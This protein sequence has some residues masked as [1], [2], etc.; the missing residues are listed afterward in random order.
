M[1]GRIAS[2]AKGSGAKSKGLRAPSGREL[3]RAQTRLAA[4][5]GR[6]MAK[7]V[8]VDALLGGT[9]VRSPSSPWFGS[10]VRHV[11]RVL[12]LFEQ[13]HLRTLSVA[14]LEGGP[15]AN[16]RGMVFTFDRF[17][18]VARIQ[19]IGALG[20][21]RLLEQ[22]LIDAAKALAEASPR[23]A[24]PEGAVFP[25][26]YWEREPHSVP[27]DGRFHVRDGIRGSVALRDLFEHPLDYSLD[28][29]M[30]V[31]VVY[32]KALLSLLGDGAFDSHFAPL[33]L[34][35]RIG[36]GPPHSEAALAEWS[37]SNLAPRV[38]LSPDA[39]P[40]STLIYLGKSPRGKRLFYGHPF[41]ITTDASMNR[42]LQAALPP[43][44]P[45]PATVV[46]PTELPAVKPPED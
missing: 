32:F 21:R 16:N 3:T 45:P 33:T 29:R 2:S 10:M 41:G 24:F 34:S 19:P 28:A 11:E 36:M 13:R 7:V 17:N 18:R 25:S 1:R 31:Q 35:S 4:D 8:L 14:G 20:N 38:A 9:P 5:L 46:T 40:G 15:E 39:W 23:F 37:A 44:T 43:N 26:M 6:A 22:S 42:Y 27:A 12:H 30:A